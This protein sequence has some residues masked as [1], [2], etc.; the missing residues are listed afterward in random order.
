MFNNKSIL[1]SEAVLLTAK[2]CGREGAKGGNGRD[3]WLPRVVQE[4]PYDVL[5]V[6]DEGRDNRR[7]ASGSRTYA[8]IRGFPNGATQCIPS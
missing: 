8:L 5:D 3:R 2:R 6:Q 4:G 1:R 7:Y